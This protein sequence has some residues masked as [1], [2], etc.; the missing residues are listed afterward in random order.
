M[1]D[2]A[3][4]AR[5][6]V[7]WRTIWAAIFSVL[8]AYVGVRTYLALTH[9]V[10][11]LV[12]ALFFTIVLNPAVDFLEQRAHLRRGFATLIVFLVGLG[13]LAGMLYAF[14]RPL[15]EQVSNF[16]EDLPGYVD[17]ARDGKGTVGDLVDRYNLQD[18]VE[19]N[20]EKL[21]DSV[22]G[23][24][25]P[26]LDV[27]RTVFSGI[28]AAVTAMVLTILMLLQAPHLTSGILNLVPDDRRER[29]R[30]VAT[31]ASRAVSGYVFGN[32]VISVIAGT[33][34]WIV[35]AILGVPYAGVLGLFVAFTDL[36]PLVGA[37]LGAVPTVLFAFLYS[38]PAGISTV[39]FFIIY[40]QF[41]NHVLQVSIM[42]RTV[43][44][45]PLTVLVSVLVGVELF[46]ILGALLAIP[47]A[48]GALLIYEEVLVPRQRHH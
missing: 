4:L 37:T 32:V 24:G 26:A 40:Q 46:G 35:L 12:V 7:P 48:A 3:P 19:K 28:F 31:D 45:N 9:I 23:L 6:P 25:A 5:Q 42:S 39:I 21:R 13:L 30:R 27:A 11:F 17:D 18:Y 41:E 29:V 22:S 44:V 14:I 34:A 43:D 20:D 33:S 36:I 38:V 1:P 10:T 16:A 47:F 2:S 8:L 15:V